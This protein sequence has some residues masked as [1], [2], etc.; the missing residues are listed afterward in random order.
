MNNFYKFGAFPAHQAGVRQ[1]KPAAHTQGTTHMPRSALFP[2]LFCRT[3]RPSHSQG[4]LNHHFVFP[5]LEKFPDLQTDSA[6]LGRL[7]DRDTQAETTASAAVWAQKPL[8]GQEISFARAEH[9][10]MSGCLL[11]AGHGIIPVIKLCKHFDKYGLNF[12]F[13]TKPRTRHSSS[14]PPH[15]LVQD[16]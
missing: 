15:S 8:Q 1:P 11:A 16:L 14:G 7:T 13:M 4:S 6:E 10:K 3:G 5:G 2:K 12:Q 9:Y